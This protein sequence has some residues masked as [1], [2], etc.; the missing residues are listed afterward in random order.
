MAVEKQ[1]AVE[2]SQK[3]HPLE[4]AVASM[5][6]E[7]LSGEKDWDRNF[8]AAVAAAVAAIGGG[9]AAAAGVASPAAFT[10][11]AGLANHHEA[12]MRS[13]LSTYRYTPLMSQP[14]EGWEAAA[15]DVCALPLPYG[16]IEAP[17]LALDPSAYRLPLSACSM[18][19]QM[20]G[21]RSQLAASER[22]MLLVAL[23]SL[24][25]TELARR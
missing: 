9:D 24:E 19:R 10:Q 2:R 7:A 3:L 21:G 22:D 18:E 17:P 5:Q 8:D 11:A 4:R 23:Q 25:S 14:P 15:E 16:G 6:W 20:D 1:V 13:Y 12:E